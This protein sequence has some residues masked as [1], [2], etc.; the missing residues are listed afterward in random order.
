MYVIGPPGSGRVKIGTSVNPSKRLKELQTGNPDRLE[1]L[2]TAPG[3]RELESALHQTFN[4]YRIEGEWF[5][6]GAVEPVGAIPRAVHAYANPKPR[7]QAATSPLPRAPHAERSDVI[8]PERLAGIVRDVVLGARH[9]PDPEDE[10]DPEEVLPHRTARV[11][12]DMKRVLGF[13]Y[14]RL[15]SNHAD[16]NLQGKRGF[17]A[18]GGW[19][20]LTYFVLTL[21]L[22]TPIGAFL[23][24]RT[25]ARDI[26]PVRKLPLLALFGFAA[27]DMFGFDRLIRD[28]V[29]SR[30][31]LH[32][33]EWFL[34]TYFT[35]AA[36]TSAWLLAWTGLV[37]PVAGYALLL[38][39]KKE[40]AHEA[41][42]RAK[43]ERENEQTRVQE[44]R[45]SSAALAATLVAPSPHVQPPPIIDLIRAA[46][47]RQATEEKPV[48]ASVTQEGPPQNDEGNVDNAPKPGR[49]SPPS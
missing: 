17:A 13:L 2:W 36:T 44:E 4:A 30:L 5:D 16:R 37:M 31:P 45:L 10:T 25:V 24:L 48:R 3:G 23:T 33:I 43:A 18:F 6:F 28:Q 39:E 12:R 22:A 27:W 29:L 8:T 11:D 19:R 49:P 46:V 20:A 35:E 32:D 7:G 26:W 34:R 1:V 15:A 21:P 38:T 9:S 42:A 41:E 40:E 14:G 47:P